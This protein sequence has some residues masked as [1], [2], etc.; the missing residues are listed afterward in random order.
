MLWRPYGIHFSVADTQVWL[1]HA[2]LLGMFRPIYA[3]PHRL[4]DG[5]FGRGK[6]ESVVSK[7]GNNSTREGKGRD[8]QRIKGSKTKT[9]KEGT[10]SRL[11]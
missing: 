4:F 2:G 3:W 1:Y 11:L 5:I 6:K 7:S 10:I 9:N 8:P